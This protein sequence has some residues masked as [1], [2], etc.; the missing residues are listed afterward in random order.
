MVSPVVLT[1]CFAHFGADPD[2]VAVGHGLDGAA[3]F[4]AVESAFDGDAGFGA[5][6]FF[7]VERNADVGGAG[8]VGRALDDGVEFNHRKNFS[9]D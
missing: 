1:Q 4:P 2:D 7:N 6:N 5:E 3:V 9:L 8:G